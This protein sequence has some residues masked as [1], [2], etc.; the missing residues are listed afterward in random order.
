MN[1][2]KE[3]LRR[4]SGSI[5]ECVEFLT[6]GGCALAGWIA[7][8]ATGPALAARDS[9]EGRESADALAGYGPDG[10]RLFLQYPA[11]ARERAKLR[12]QA[13]A[14][15]FEAVRNGRMKSEAERASANEWYKLMPSRKHRKGRL[16]RL[17]SRE[18]TIRKWVSR[19]ERR[20][21]FEAA[22]LSAF[23]DAKSSPHFRQRNR[24]QT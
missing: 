12:R 22:P 18:R 23:L 19:I 5:L 11:S 7:G 20:G 2:R 15:Y 1:R 24:R 8:L 10:E 9:T 4:A 16:N 17:G 21:G 14:V 3:Q 6:M 13:L